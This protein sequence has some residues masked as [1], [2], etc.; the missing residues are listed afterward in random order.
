MQTILPNEVVCTGD[1]TSERRDVLSVLWAITKGCNFRCSYCAYN[2][3]LKSTQFSSKDELL[4]AAR[5]IER[6]GRPGYQI[7]LYGG[8]PTLHPHFLDLLGHFAAS[9]A[10]VALRTYTNGSRSAGFF[11]RVIAAA[12][13]YY[14]GV[15]FSFHPD[16]GHF[17]KFER[18]VE[19]VAGSGM[20]VGVSFMFVPSRREQ[21]RRQMDELLK[22]RMKVPFFLS[23][24][25]PYLPN[26][27]MGTGCTDADLAW[28][29]ATRAAF[30]RQPI[31]AR[32]RTPFYTRIMSRIDV[33]R[34]GRRVRLAPEDS[35]QLLSWMRTPSYA[36]YYCCGGTNVMFVEED[37]TARGGV[38]SA[39]P[40]LGNVFRDSAVVLAQAMRPVRC[41]SIACASIENIPLPKFRNA[42][43]AE[44]CTVEFRNRAK[45]YVYRAEAARLNGSQAVPVRNGESRLPAR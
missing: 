37:G 23:L 31:P 42:A 20:S 12:R 7:T 1:Y 39:S 38:C 27:V 35:L 18:N 43:E 15:I 25:H 2:K 13:D 14:F 17:E 22:L 5:T 6:L 45:A 41:T 40:C 28:M 33:E 44:A 26:G 11:E 16:F 8:E 3:D 34:G 4:R 21:A 24:N 19:L 29:A 36:D 10:P 32:L 30:D 9:S